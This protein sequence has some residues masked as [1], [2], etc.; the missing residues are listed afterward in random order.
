MKVA[1]ITNMPPPYRNEV[2]RL[3][4]R[5]GLSIR[6]LFCAKTEPN[7]LWNVPE[8]TYDHVYMRGM[9]F[10]KK[11]DGA[12]VHLNFQ[13]WSELNAY[14]PDCVITT[15]FNPTHL[16]A[17]AWSRI[18]GA[19]H[20]CMTDG[21]LRSESVLSRKHRL[22]R[23]LVFKRSRAFLA[24]SQSGIALYQAYGIDQNGCFQS[25][26]CANNESFAPYANK[27]ERKYDILFS[28]RF[29]EVKQPLFFVEVAKELQRRRGHIKVLLIGSGPLQEATLAKLDDSGIEYDYPGFVQ[30]DELPEMY[31]NARILLFTTNFDPW[32][33][34]ANEAMAAGTPVITA[35]AAGVAGELVVD[36][37]TGFVRDLIVDQWA[38]AAMHLLDDP[39]EWQRFSQKAFGKVQQY[40]YQ[41]AADG[42]VA[43][44]RY[45]EASALGLL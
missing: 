27:G 5:A 17:F 1:M 32:G 42:I 20:I 40:N 16:L 4:S 28:G 6:L 10:E 2:Y 43:A 25:H 31:S 36:G 35:P 33:V 3:I 24:A 37:E 29:D 12:Y 19:H 23:K 26:L 9:V 7:R 45:A 18:Y 11:R 13:V 34:V 14:R 38:D 44:C 8:H 39:G 22:V 30:Q 15:G 21:T 41:A